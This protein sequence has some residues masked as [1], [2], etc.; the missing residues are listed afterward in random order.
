M[1]SLASIFNKLF[2]WNRVALQ[3]K[4]IEA[5][6]ANNRPSKHDMSINLPDPFKLTILIYSVNLSW[7]KMI[8]L[9]DTKVF[10]KLIDKYHDLRT[11]LTTN[12]FSRAHFSK[13]LNKTQKPKTNT[14]RI[15]RRYFH[16]AIL[17]TLPSWRIKFSNNPPPPGH[18]VQQQSAGSIKIG[19]LQPNA[20]FGIGCNQSHHQNQRIATNSRSWNWPQSTDFYRFSWLQPNSV[21]GWRV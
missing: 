16:S 19:G 17:L 15:K 10:G 21:I 8:Y 5:P 3:K 18:R 6:T 14:K 7:F 2:M 13:T 11:Y 1:I 4:V 9:I 20:P 12:L